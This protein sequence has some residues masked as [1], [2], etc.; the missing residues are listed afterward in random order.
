LMRFTKLKWTS[1]T[2]LDTS[3]RTI[4]HFM[5]LC[6]S[7]LMRKRKWDLKCGDYSTVYLHPNLF[8]TW[9]LTWR[10]SRIARLVTGL[11]CSHRVLPIDYSTRS[12]SSNTWCLT[13][14]RLNK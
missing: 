9:S 7:F 5:I 13:T 4:T 6:S 12:K 2:F 8:L 14:L 3:S 10:V 11:K 1:K